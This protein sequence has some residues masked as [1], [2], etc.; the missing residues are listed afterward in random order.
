MKCMRKLL[1]LVLVSLVGVGM[2][3]STQ[4]LTVSPARVEITGDPGTVLH[5]EIEL[6]NEQEETKTFFISY[7]NFEP[8]GDSGAPHFMGNNDGLATWIKSENKLI[9]EPGQRPVVP[10]FVF[11]PEKT[12][13]GGYF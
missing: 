1:Y 9:P 12:E 7:E 3:T 8:S 6:F 4:A 2:A 5:S 13:T 11:L 10:F